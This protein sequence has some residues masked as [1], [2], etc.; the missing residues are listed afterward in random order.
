MFQPMLEFRSQVQVY[1]LCTT[2]HFKMEKASS[3]SH[4]ENPLE[5]LAIDMNRADFVE[6]VVQWP[7]FLK[8]I[9]NGR[10]RTRT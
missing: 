4:N 8:K 1:L 6:R 7:T 9:E 2:C 5:K 3:G 10:W